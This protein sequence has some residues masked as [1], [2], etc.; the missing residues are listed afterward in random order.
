MAEIKRILKIT[1]EEPNLSERKMGEIIGCSKNT[2][3]AIKTIAGRINIIY[4]LNIYSIIKIK[5]LLKSSPV[6]GATS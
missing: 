1:E 5:F 4:T 6:V 3:K 2:I